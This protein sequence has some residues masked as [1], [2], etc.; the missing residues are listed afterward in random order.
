[1]ADASNNMPVRREA[2]LDELGGRGLALLDELSDS[3]GVTTPTPHG[4][5]V[6]FELAG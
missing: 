4:K 5:V 2:G 6:W 1:V 3:W